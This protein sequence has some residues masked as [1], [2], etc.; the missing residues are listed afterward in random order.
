MAYD[1]AAAV[2]ANTSILL[3]P[4]PFQPLPLRT[5]V[6]C[7]VVEVGDLVVR[8]NLTAQRQNGLCYLPHP[9]T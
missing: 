3:I 7:G 8:A 6:N 5:L 2:A 4:W 9:N 1:T